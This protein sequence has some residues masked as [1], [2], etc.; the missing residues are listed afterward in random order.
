MMNKI[1]VLNL[2]ATIYHLGE[3]EEVFEPFAD[4]LMVNWGKEF[5]LDPDEPDPIGGVKEQ[6]KTSSYKGSDMKNIWELGEPQVAI[7]ESIFDTMVYDFMY[8]KHPK[9][10]GA[11]VNH[12]LHKDA[13]LTSPSTWQHVRIHRHIEPFIRQ[14][15]VGDIVTVFYAYLDDSISEDNGS[16][17]FFEGTDPDIP[18]EAPDNTTPVFTYVP[19]L[20]DLLIM[21]TDV[22][23]RAHPFTGNRYSLATDIR[24]Q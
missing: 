16:I 10:K 7:A 19:R 18:A 1:D 11:S 24:V 23:H 9:F 20:Y 12:T 6:Q 13:W 8:E 4:R 22:W 14:E 21:T 5:I 2:P 3:Y 15:Q 17:Q